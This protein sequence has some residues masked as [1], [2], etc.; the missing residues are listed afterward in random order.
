MQDKTN[1]HQRGPFVSKN[2]IF[3]SK[4][5]SVVKVAT[6]PK[7]HLELVLL[8]KSRERLS[9]NMQECTVSSME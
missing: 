3:Q 2:L 6:I 8:R 9:N 4:S 5:R 1:F 7:F